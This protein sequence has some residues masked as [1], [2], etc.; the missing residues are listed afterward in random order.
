V[1]ALLERSN[2]NLV[3]SLIGLPF[4]DRA[5]YFE[6]LLPHLYEMRART[7]RPHWIF[8]DETHHVAP[9]R[10]QPSGL[11]LPPEPHNLV[12]ITVRPSQVAPSLLNTVGTGFFLG[13]EAREALAE[14][15]HA[16][17]VDVPPATGPLP[18]KGQ[19]LAWSADQPNEPFLFQSRTPK[20]ERRRHVRK[21]A[22]GELEPERSFYFR[23]P[24]QKLNL[25]AHNLDL[26]VQMAS[27]VDD[28]TWQYHLEQGDYSRWFRE[29][30]KDPE[31]AD[32]AKQV[33]EHPT[34]DAN[35]S[36]QRIRNAIESRYT[37][38]A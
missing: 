23:G 28:D 24:G 14:L 17:G 26:F 2:E 27:G 34:L 32:E 4:A 6:T 30:I 38:A 12:F 35:D 37:A 36:R 13:S 18:E 25:R 7:G 15:A 3:V 31:L 21:Y 9:V 33:E 16:K 20:A 1:L 11:T 5:Q 8:V 19:A 29:G 10:R 22:T